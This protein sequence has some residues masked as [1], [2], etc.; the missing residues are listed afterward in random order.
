VPRVPRRIFA[1]SSSPA[2]LFTRT[3][4]PA[5]PFARSVFPRR[6]VKSASVPLELDPPFTRAFQ[7]EQRADQ[8]CVQPMSAT[9]VFKEEHPLYRAVSGFVSRSSI[10]PEDGASRGDRPLQ[11]SFRRSS[12]SISPAPAC[13]EMTSL[14]CFRHRST[15][16]GSSPTRFARPRPLRPPSAL[17]MMACKRPETP[18]IDKG[19]LLG[20]FAVV[21]V[22]L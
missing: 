2:R 13:R 22:A 18:S 6:P 20:S 4:E 7:R 21:P 17:M 3:K 9:Y 14:W 19:T 10:S 1:R 12:A 5:H 11:P 8:R 15:L 16:I